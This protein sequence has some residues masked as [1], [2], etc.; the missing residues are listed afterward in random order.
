M[1]Q[2]TIRVSNSELDAFE[3]LCTAWLLCPKHGALKPKTRT[4]RDLA[5]RQYTCKNC[6]GEL[7]AAQAKAL[8]LWTRLVRAYD[9]RPHQT[10][11]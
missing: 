11:R 6:Y 3:D 4:E 10:T 9:A 5:I 8:R 2:L 7:Q 1:K